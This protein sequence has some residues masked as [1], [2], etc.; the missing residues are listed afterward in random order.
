MAIAWEGFEAPGRLA[1]VERVSAERE[2]FHE[3]FQLEFR[4]V[5]AAAMVRVAEGELRWHQD[6]A[7][8]VRSLIARRK[9]ARR[10]KQLVR[11]SE[12][13]VFV[14][15]SVLPAALE[16][17]QVFRRKQRELPPGPETGDRVVTYLRLGV[18][19]TRDVRRDLGPK[20]P[21]V[22]PYQYRR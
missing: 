10:K 18:R 22:M 3:Q 13:E 15:R 14:E 1:R 16:A 6:Q 12:R 11:A 8:F 4:V 5:L 2:A 21:R 9:V 19:N 17:R 7:H 20:I